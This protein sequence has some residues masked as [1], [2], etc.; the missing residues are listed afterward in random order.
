M[1]AQA[2]LNERRASTLDGVRSVASIIDEHVETIERERLLPTAVAS[3]LIDAG[4]FRMLVPRSLGG[5]EL[6]PLTVCAVVEELSIRDGAVGWC[7]M[8]G[9]CNGLFGGLL[10]RAG[11]AEIYADRDVVLAGQ[12]R[13]SGTAV[14]VD[15]GYRVTGRW[16]FASGIMH[17]QWLMGGCQIVEPSGAG[18]GAAKLMFMPR[19]DATVVD[20][21]HVGGLRGTGSHDFEV[22]DVFVPASRTVSFAD[23]PVEAGPLYSL[24]SIAMFA[25]MIASV[26]LGIARHAIEAFKQLG[27]VKKPTFS[28]GLLRDGAVAQ[29]HL[30]E[31]EAFLRA[32]RA[33]LFESLR[34]AWQ[35]AQRGERLT[36]HDRGLLW[37]SATQAVTQALHAVDL[38]YRAGGAASVYTSTQLE[39]CLRDIRTASQHVT[40]M[41]T[42]YEVAGQFFF[43]ADVSRTVWSRDSKRTD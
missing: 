19:S 5:D 4:A 35:V 27:G 18:T 34:S 32:G 12:F 30:G 36:W 24:P 22:K 21:W 1:V 39:R 9:A 20:T 33:F 37:L 42:N 15:G 25:T 14:Q 10:P 28:Q 31:A 38:V 7:A 26:P 13:L 11:A 29:S 3:A 23:P 8:I 2:A 41:A 6:D 17:S 16:P 40:V 43:G